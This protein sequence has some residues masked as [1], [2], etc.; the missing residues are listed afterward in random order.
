MKLRTLFTFTWLPG[1]GLACATAAAYDAT[2]EVP[3]WHMS[4]FSRANCINNESISWDTSGAS[5][6]NLY[7]QSYQ[8]NLDDFS[9]VFISAGSEV[10]WRS[11]AV[12]WFAA[13]E[14]FWQVEG[15]HLIQ[16]APRTDPNEGWALIYQNCT[17][18]FGGA[19]NTLEECVRTFADDCSF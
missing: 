9:E 3:V 1:L 6:W 8:T 14:G 17:D 7:T 12:A 5:Y 18:S 11:A 15:Y 2:T 4:M 16:P 13:G 19:T 10:T